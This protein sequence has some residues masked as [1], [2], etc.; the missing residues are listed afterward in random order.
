MS[1]TMDDVCRRVNNYSARSCR[2]LRAYVQRNTRWISIEKKGSFQTLKR[3]R[4]EQEKVQN[5]EVLRNRNQSRKYKL[6]KRLL[7]SYSMLIYVDGCRKNLFK[8]PI[9]FKEEEVRSLFYYLHGIK[10]I[11]IIYLLG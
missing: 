6:E 9:C 3:R 11:K 7:G 5:L 8:C 10:N 4:L 1:T 2:T